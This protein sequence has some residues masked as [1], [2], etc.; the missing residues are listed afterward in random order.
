MRGRTIS[1]VFVGVVALAIVVLAAAESGHVAA[2]QQ[3]DSHDAEQHAP[4]GD[5]PANATS[6]A[7]D[8]P[9][10]G[11]DGR[12]DGSASAAPNGTA[13]DGDVNSV[14]LN[15]R[16]ELELAMEAGDVERLDAAVRASGQVPPELRETGAC[17]S[18]LLKHGT[19]P[20]ARPFTQLDGHI[21]ADAVALGNVEI[22]TYLLGT[23]CVD[24]TGSPVDGGG[25]SP[26]ALAVA[27]GDVDMVSL[28]MQW[29]AD[30]STCY[31]QFGSNG[32]VPVIM[33]AWMQGNLEMVGVLAE[34]DLAAV[35]AAGLGLITAA[36]EGDA[37]D[38]NAALLAVAHAHGASAVHRGFH[39]GLTPAAMAARF[40]R[41]DALRALLDAGACPTPTDCVV[42]AM[43]AV[44]C[45]QHETLEWLVDGK[46]VDLSLE[47][48]GID[49]GELATYGADFR[50]FRWMVRNGH[51]RATSLGDAETPALQSI[52]AGDYPLPTE[53]LEYLINHALSGDVS[54]DFN[55]RARTH[56]EGVTP[57][58]H[59]AWAGDDRRTQLLLQGGADV[60]IE[61][62]R[63]LNAL[64][65]ALCGCH[66]DVAD[67]LLSAGAGDCA[68]MRAEV[69]A[70]AT[71]GRLVQRSRRSAAFRRLKR[72]LRHGRC[73]AQTNESGDGEPGLCLRE[74]R[75]RVSRGWGDVDGTVIQ[76]GFPGA[77][78]DACPTPTP[79]AALGWLNGEY[80]NELREDVV[81]ERRCAVRVRA[82]GDQLGRDAVTS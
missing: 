41:P 22:L 18:A 50:V 9:V 58:H 65:Y 54:L 44:L 48:N 33:D 77:F 71:G 17:E 6:R 39:A 14:W 81:F 45:G 8:E 70:G 82:D 28:L 20:A 66:V 26:L 46:H 36:I 7:D 34:A 4:D 21:L 13:G 55:E 43:S 64:E 51:Y 75:N 68:E 57:L 73:A 16:E 25:T 61:S 5:R 31:I 79:Y 3:L 37:A 63:G 35:G 11:D 74:F 49:L 42:V 32:H 80:A 23:A 30:P 52:V 38:V 19:D 76:D 59:T 29:G 1:I 72:L 10:A 69:V 78:P 40:C 12:I 15:W 24:P 56:G 27:L 60:C 62:K 53:E 47:W 2:G 67:R